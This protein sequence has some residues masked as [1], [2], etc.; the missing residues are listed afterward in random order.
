MSFQPTVT[1]GL[2]SKKTFAK[3]C[4]EANVR[5]IVLPPFSPTT[6]SL[7]GLERGLDLRRLQNF[8]FDLPVGGVSQFFPT[9]EG[10]FIL[11]VRAILPFDEAKAKTEMPVYVAKVQ[12]ARQNDA[13]NAWFR[14]QAEGGRLN[15]PQRE[16]P[17]FGAPRPTGRGR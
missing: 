1:N 17:A 5:H 10:G 8:A 15:I 12:T 14:K 4:E 9:Q 3:I 7:P 13:F 16:T 11:Y 6:Q 2:A